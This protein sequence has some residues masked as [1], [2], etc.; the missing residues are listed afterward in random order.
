MFAALFFT[1][2]LFAFGASIIAASVL[3]C[4]SWARQDMEQPPEGR[5]FRRG[6]L[7]KLPSETGETPMTR[8]AEVEPFVR[9]RVQSYKDASV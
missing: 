3:L 7:Q 5:L 6:D 8:Q 1:L 2:C 9:G 4:E